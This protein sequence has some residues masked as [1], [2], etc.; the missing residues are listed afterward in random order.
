MPTFPI[1]PMTEIVGVVV[2]HLKKNVKVYQQLS[3]QSNSTHLFRVSP[4]ERRGIY[5][6]NPKLTKQA[7]GKL[8]QLCVMQQ[9]ISL[10]DSISCSWQFLLL[11]QSLKLAWKM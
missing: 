4:I 8:S 10:A 6:K 9:T 3:L 5:G 2:V 7:T 1:T 11:F